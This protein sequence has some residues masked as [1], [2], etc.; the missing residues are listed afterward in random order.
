MHEAEE[1]K[2]PCLVPAGLLAFTQVKAGLGLPQ[3]SSCVTWGN[4]FTSLNLLKREAVMPRP[5]GWGRGRR[6][7]H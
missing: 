1:F 4:E 7:G 3:A 2:P 5:H 6:E